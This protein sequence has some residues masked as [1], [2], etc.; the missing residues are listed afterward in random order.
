MQVCKFLLVWYIVSTVLQLLFS[1]PSYQA[2]S[3]GINWKWVYL[4][5]W[6][7]MCN[8]VKV[9]DL[10]APQQSPHRDTN[11]QQT[12]IDSYLTE[13]QQSLNYLVTNLRQRSYLAWLVYFLN[14]MQYGSK[15]LGTGPFPLL[16]LPYCNVS[17]IM[18]TMNNVHIW[19]VPQAWQDSNKQIQNCGIWLTH[20]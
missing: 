1:G 7:R 2:C 13:F 3:A 9:E 8:Y 15:L 4:V 14:D 18:H 17:I 11:H 19:Y 20:A 16:L 12:Q 5:K 6:L 10:K